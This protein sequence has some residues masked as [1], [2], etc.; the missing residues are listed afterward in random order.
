LANAR[1]AG[2]AVVVAT[3][4]TRQRIRTPEF[5]DFLNFCR[6][7]DYPLAYLW[8]KLTGEW[9]GAAD[10]LP[11]P[12]DVAFMAE[13]GKEY[14]LLDRTSPWFGLDVGCNAMKRSLTITDIGDV[15]ACHWMYFSFGNVWQEPLG[16]ITARGME[17]FAPKVTTCRVSQD[18]NFIAK[19][20]HPTFGRKSTEHLLNATDVLGSVADFHAHVPVPVGSPEAAGL[21]VIGRRELPVLAAT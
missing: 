18:H 6:D 13:I 2:L 10:A 1:N 8:P 11:L 15:L 7:H 16:Q 14:S 21:P 19:Y 12:E 3:V 20:I 4:V 17:Y 5:R 9:E